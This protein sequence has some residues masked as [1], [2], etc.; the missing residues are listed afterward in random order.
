MK[1]IMIMV[2]AVL[3]SSLLLAGCMKTPSLDQ[4]VPGGL[5]GLIGQTDKESPSQT[6]ELTDIVP[7]KT[8]RVDPDSGFRNSY[9]A[10]L[11]TF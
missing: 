7:E 5:G 1:K 9:E 11:L 4:L 10:Y 2:S 6:I 3:V 8:D